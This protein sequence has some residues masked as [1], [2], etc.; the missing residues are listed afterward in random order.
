MDLQGYNKLLSS[1]QTLNTQGGGQESSLLQTTLDPTLSSKH[2]GEQSEK[3][4]KIGVF[5]LINSRKKEGMKVE[6]SIHQRKWRIIQGSLP[7]EEMSKRMREK[8]RK[9]GI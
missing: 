4:R 1:I 7:H 2:N 6:V 9:K 8:E 3:G 5:T